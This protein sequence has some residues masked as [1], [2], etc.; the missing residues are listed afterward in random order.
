MKINRQ[1][2][3][4]AIRESIKLPLKLTLQMDAEH[5]PPMTTS[6]HILYIG[7]LCM[8]ISSSAEASETEILSWMT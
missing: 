1:P 5:I 3:G 2:I 6:C 8:R 7:V 4:I